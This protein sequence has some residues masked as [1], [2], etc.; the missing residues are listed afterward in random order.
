MDDEMF[1]GLSDGLR[2]GSVT[3]VMK[4]LNSGM[5][6][7]PAQVVVL[8]PG[9]RAN[10]AEASLA[11]L[12]TYISMGLFVSVALFATYVYFSFFKKSSKKIYDGKALPGI[13]EGLMNALE[14][15]VKNEHPKMILKDTKIIPQ[16]APHSSLHSSPQQSTTHNED[17]VYIQG[18]LPV[19]NLPESSQDILEKRV[20][21]SD[22]S[23]LNLVKSREAFTKDLEVNMAKG[24]KTLA[25]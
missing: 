2:A 25:A 10:A 22:Q 6:A 17:V 8:V 4:P 21:E 14:S 24:I 1:R 9:N 5:I 11:S 19:W 7:E 20:D 15:N 3:S 16:S 13:S 23:I 12:K 18:P